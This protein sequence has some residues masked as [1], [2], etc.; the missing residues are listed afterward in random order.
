VATGEST[1]LNTILSVLEKTAAHPVRKQYAPARG[2]DI[3]HSAGS[4]EG[5][6]SCGWRPKVTLERGIQE[7]LNE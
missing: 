7:L 4:S 3:V 2:G 1:S 6:Q 5:L